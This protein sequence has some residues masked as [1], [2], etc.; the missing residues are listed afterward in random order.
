MMKEQSFTV[1]QLNRYIARIFSEDF[2]LR[3]ITVSGE[4][5]NLKYHP[6]GHIYFTLKDE[7]S[8]LSAVLF[9]GERAGLNFTLENGRRVLV[10]GRVAVYQR[11]GS[12]QLYAEKIRQE[13]LGELYIRYER[14]KQELMDMGM[15]DAMYKKPIPEFCR[16]IGIVTAKTGAAVRDIIQIAKRRNPYVELVLFPAIVQGDK[17]AASIVEGIETLDKLGLDVI[18]VGRGGGSLEDLWA[19]NERAVAEAVFNAD[20][21]IISAVGHE[22]DT[23]ICDFAADLRAPTPSAAAELAVFDI[24]ELDRKIEALRAEL[25]NRIQGRLSEKKQRLVYLQRLL[26]RESP[27]A[28]VRQERERL[29]QLE[30]K[31][32]S[33]MYD[34]IRDCRERLSAMPE[35]KPM[36][37]RKLEKAVAELLIKTERL[38]A[39]SPLKK[40][41][42]GYGYIQSQSG[43]RVDSVEKTG[44]GELI[45]IS[46]MDGK[47]KSRVE[48]IER[49]PGGK[50]DRG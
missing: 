35:L 24:R 4:I 37:E 48:S 40:L 31:I 12:Y 41:T 16:R 43:S 45:D 25:Y 15:F 6:S 8:Q 1:S 5:S 29:I 21:A 7:T 13:G 47:I 10:S 17:A 30:D 2:S 27:G 26:Y 49:S 28:R 33:S 34:K 22:T 18:I 11:G 3:C 32:R 36:M 44:I 23:S 42:Q 14:L 19:F 50:N 39:L 9:A 20:T 46:L 38:E